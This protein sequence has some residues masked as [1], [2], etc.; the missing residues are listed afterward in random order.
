M[1]DAYS[2]LIAQWASPPAKC[3]QGC[4]LGVCFCVRQAA[5]VT[6]DPGIFQALLIV[7][8]F[9]FTHTHTHLCRKLC[10]AGF[11]GY[12]FPWQTNAEIP[13]L[14][15]KPGWWKRHPRAAVSI[16]RTTRIADW[17]LGASWGV[18]GAD[19]GRVRTGGASPF[20]ARYTRSA[21]WFTLLS[22]LLQR[23]RAHGRKAAREP[24]CGLVAA[25]D[26]LTRYPS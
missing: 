3:E 12:D 2:I 1:I 7:R 6:D 4:N 14:G 18:P 21:S 16:A 26:S 15:S 8:L 11:Q 13:E 20:F 9:Y 19:A 10:K 24:D 25:S 22:A 5:T 17:P 23:T